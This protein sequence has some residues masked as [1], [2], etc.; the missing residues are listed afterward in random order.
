[1]TVDLPSSKIIRTF[2]QV[3]RL[4]EVWFDRA[5]D[6]HYPAAVGNPCGPVLGV[7]DARADRWVAN[8][9]TGPHAHSVAADLDT[10][11]V[12]VPIT[13]TKR[14]AQC[15]AGCIAVFSYQHGSWETHR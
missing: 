5:Q 8:V 4:D 3:G 7:I 13:A 1:M 14:D 9:P 10:G 6:V 15:D 12:F 11:Q 2:H